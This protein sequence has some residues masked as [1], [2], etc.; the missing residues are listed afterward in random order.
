[1]LPY[2]LD[3]GRAMISYVS[4]GKLKEGKALGRN[5][6]GRE[7]KRGP[8]DRVRPRQMDNSSGKH[9]NTNKKHPWNQK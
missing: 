6:Q 1:M 2:R 8:P 9:Q 5:I 7:G 3:G 4:S